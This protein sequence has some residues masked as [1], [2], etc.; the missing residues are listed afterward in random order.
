MNSLPEK[1]TAIVFFVGVV[2][3]KRLTHMMNESQDGVQEEEE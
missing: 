3:K 1:L 2:W